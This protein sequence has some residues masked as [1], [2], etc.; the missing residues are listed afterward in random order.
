MQTLEG[1]QENNAQ[2]GSVAVETP[3]PSSEDL[4]FVFQTI[5]SQSEQGAD[6]LKHLTILLCI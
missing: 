1:S 3:S 4:P 5:P 2:G 6:R